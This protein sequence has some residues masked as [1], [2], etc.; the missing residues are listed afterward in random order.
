LAVCR[1]LF[2][3][4]LNP[5]YHDPVKRDSDQL[6]PHLFRTE[7]S[8]ITSVL[9]KSFGIDH[10]ETAEDIASETFLAAME[11]WPYKGV[12][13]NPVGWLYSVARN[14]TRNMLVHDSVFR[15][16]IAQT[17]KQ[18]E[19]VVQ[20]IELDLTES[21]IHDSQLRMLFAICHPAIA[22]EAQIGLALRILCGFGID[23][24]ADAFLS[25]KETINKR[26]FR[27]RERLKAENASLQF[28]APAE[29]RVRL[30]NVL[31]T[32]YL[33][34]SEGYYSESHNEVLREDLCKD[35][36][37]LTRLLLDGR[38]TS[39]PQVH[40][41]LSL[42]CFHASRFSAR[43]DQSGALV[44][45]DQQD[46]SLWDRNLIAKGA[47]HLHL[48]SRGNM[49]SRYHVEANIAYWHTIKSDTFEKWDSILQLYNNLLMIQYSPLA[50]L[51]RTYALFKVK[52]RQVAIAEAEK[53]D[54]KDN[55]FYFTLLGELYRE[56]DDA[57]SKSN[58][59]RALQLAKTSADKEMIRHKL[60]KPAM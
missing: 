22:P 37:R 8:K 12:P 53:L 54:I 29:L 25:N 58:L 32:L 35:A 46:E 26:L 43:K 33:L 48:A 50:A 44:L 55:H 11:T 52:G 60:D 31:T 57:K 14:K 15:K 20:E 19:N 9:C 30:D 7:F 59:E 47:E 23:E 36:M 40:A 39:E 41:L 34:F 45:Y 38:D 4:D 5:N 42:M 17:L 28:P 27:A 18:Q 24:I 1:W 49:V 51:N 2:K 6:I 10:V 13:E 56:V 21:N 3:R 16:K